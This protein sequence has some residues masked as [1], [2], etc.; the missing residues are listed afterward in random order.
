MGIEKLALWST[1]VL[2]LSGACVIIAKI[3]RGYSKREE[4]VES[5]P[6]LS[7]DLASV[8]ASTL[9]LQQVLAEIR[10]NQERTFERLGGEVQRLENR[11]QEMR[12]ELVELRA[13]VRR[14]G[15]S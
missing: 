15:S 13:D 1:E 10:L 5:I 4:A 8:S 12:G 2:A 6:G 9:A 7:K 3:A 11:V 14:L